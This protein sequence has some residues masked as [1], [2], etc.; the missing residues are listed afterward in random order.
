MSIIALNWA[1]KQPLKNSTQKLVLVALADASDDYGICWPSYQSMALK[2]S[3]TRRSVI[4]CMKDLID[5]GLVKAAGR[6]NHKGQTSNAYSLN[7]GVNIPEDHP[8]KGV[9]TECHR[10]SDTVSP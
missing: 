2:C 1:F 3:I 5:E 7:I 9:V 6:Y 10:G 4:R 8:L